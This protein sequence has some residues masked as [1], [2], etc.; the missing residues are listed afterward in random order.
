[1]TSCRLPIAGQTRRYESN[2][3]QGVETVSLAKSRVTTPAKLGTKSDHSHQCQRDAAA[4]VPGARMGGVGSTKKSRNEGRTHDV[5]DNKGSIF[6]EPT[7]S[8]KIQ[9][10]APICHDIYENT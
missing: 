2:A 10:L 1:M 3:A 6:W 4:E 8:M 9:C 7:I 5:I